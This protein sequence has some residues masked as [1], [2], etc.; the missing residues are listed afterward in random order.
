MNETE[1]TTAGFEALRQ[2]GRNLW[3]AG[4]G[5]LAEIEEEGRGL[6]DRL[7]ERGRP[8]E[9][10]QKQAV[11]ELGDR[12][13]ARFREM[14]KLVRNQVRHDVKRVMQRVGVPTSDDF[15]RLAKRLEALSSQID[16]LA[17]SGA[18]KVVRVAATAPSAPG[19][20]T[21]PRATAKKKG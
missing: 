3:L 8:L 12:A 16:E 19:V 14:Q 11:D 5:A 7:V 9:E 13:G 4:L 10:R 1:T 20:K 21:K 18:A 2:T 17:T 15:A 6:F